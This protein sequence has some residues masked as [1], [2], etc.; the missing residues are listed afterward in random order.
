MPRLPPSL[1]EP[2]QQPHPADHAGHPG[3]GHEAV[4]VGVARASP[5]C[6]T[7]HH[8]DPRHPGDH[9]GDGQH[10]RDQQRI[11][12]H[13]PPRRAGRRGGPA[14][15]RAAPAGLR[16]SWPR[17]SRGSRAASSSSGTRTPNWPTRIPCQGRTDEQPL[18]EAVCPIALAWAG[19]LRGP[20]PAA[21]RRTPAGDREPH[22]PAGDHPSAP[23]DAREC[24][25]QTDRDLHEPGPPGAARGCRPG[26][27]CGPSTGPA[28]RSAG[29]RQREAVD[30][31]PTVAGDWRVVRAPSRPG[32]LRRSTG[33]G[34]PRRR[35]RHAN[36]DRCEG[37]IRK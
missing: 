26:R 8:V 19:P 35:R 9:P 29:S 13:P 34:R 24:Q 6:R 37:H 27:R 12:A 31:Q 10:A 33:H 1:G 22:R 30:C 20:W 21:G 7:R 32:S 23:P 18:I 16:N 2:G 28:A 15:P 14:G 11:A 3:R 36:R 4:R 25:R 5:G 17:R